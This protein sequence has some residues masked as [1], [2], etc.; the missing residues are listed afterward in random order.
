MRQPLRL[1]LL[2]ASVWQPAE[3]FACTLCDSPQATS[4]R[5]RLFQPDL[6][7]NLCAVSLPIALLASIVA[8]IHFE[9]ASRQ[10]Q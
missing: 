6:W 4:I 3:V 7:F 5:A 10:V 2:A 8:V 1:L 9:P